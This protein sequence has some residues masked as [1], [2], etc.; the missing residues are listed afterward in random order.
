MDRLATKF[1]KDRSAEISA[2]GIPMA[3]VTLAIPDALFLAFC[4][5][6][7]TVRREVVSSTISIL[8]DNYPSCY[9]FVIFF[10]R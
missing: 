6:S 1:S 2:S 10:N 9:V 4:F 8:S 7:Y 3:S 5:C